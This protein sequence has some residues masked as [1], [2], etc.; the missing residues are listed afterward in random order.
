MWYEI[1]VSQQVKR[2]L[3]SFGGHRQHMFATAE[4]SITTLAQCAQVYGVLKEK[5]PESEGYQITVS[6]WRK[7][8]KDIDVS[9]LV[10]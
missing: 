8:G 10:S 1:N 4:R 6:E 5:F 7:T 3:I 2:G 9:E